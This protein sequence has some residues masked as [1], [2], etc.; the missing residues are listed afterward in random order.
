MNLNRLIYKKKTK[1]RH[2]LKEHQ[3]LQKLTTSLYLKYCSATGFLHLLPDFYIIGFVKCGTTSLHEYIMQHPCVYPPKGKEINYFDRLYYKG[4]NWYK[5]AFPFKFYKYINKNI[6]GKEFQTGEASPQYIEHPHALYRVKKL[7]PNAKFIVLLRN[8]IE[9]AFSH[10][11]MNLKSGYEYRNFSD[12][13]KHE[14][15]RIQGRYEKMKNDENYYSWNYEMY[16]YIEHGLY[17]DKLKRWF[18]IFPKDQ[19][20]IIQSE[21]FLTNISETY[22]QV[23]EF[24]GLAKWE[25]KGYVLYKK[26]KYKEKMNPDLRKQL[27]EYFRPHNKGL[28]ELIGKKFDWDE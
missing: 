22:Q 24:L 6:K 3:K 1:L 16:G 18:E 27:A 28:Y 12:A 10:H 23:L 13:L 26:H 8:P 25:P 7:T 11:N 2:Q 9:R 20:L 14:P 21:E 5:A 15:E 4:I 19:F 17:A